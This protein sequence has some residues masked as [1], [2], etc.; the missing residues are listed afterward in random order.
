MPWWG[1]SLIGVAVFV[2]VYAA[3]LYSRA[4][5]RVG[6]ATSPS[7]NICLRPEDHLSAYPAAAYCRPR[8]P[9]RGGAS[10]CPMQKR[11]LAAPSFFRGTHSYG[12]HERLDESV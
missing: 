4:S 3:F 1:S 5:S 7:T 8:R 9:N 11:A 12:R 6:E 2:V 10:R